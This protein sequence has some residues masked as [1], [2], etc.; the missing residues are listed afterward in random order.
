MSVRKSPEVGLSCRQKLTIFH[1]SG[2]SAEKVL[3]TNDDDVNLDLMLKNGVKALHLSTAGVRPLE[4]KKRGMTTAALMRRL[5]YDALHLVDPVTCSEACAAFGAEEVV[6]AF[7]ATPADSVALAGSEAVSTL[8]ITV[9][10][11]LGACAGAPTEAVSV[12][13]Q[14]CAESPLRGVAAST[15]LDTGLR[16]PQL[17]QLGYG[18]TS[19]RELRGLTGPDLV[20]LGYKCV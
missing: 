13:Q 1:G 5:G 9:E 20:K 15:L 18:L 4:L 16:A 7:L 3:G 12:L 6:S 11:L 14:V 19:V 17:K 8:G 2:L 10:Q